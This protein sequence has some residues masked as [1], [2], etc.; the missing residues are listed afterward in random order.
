MRDILVVSVQKLHE[1]LFFFWFDRCPGGVLQIS[2]DVD[3]RMGAKI[4]T[5]Q[6]SL[7]LPTKPLKN[8]WTVC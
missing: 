4:K 1:M 7:G 2:S 3:D 8:P 6:K 5:P